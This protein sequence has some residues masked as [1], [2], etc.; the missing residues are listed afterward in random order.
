MNWIGNALLLTSVCALG[1]L[2]PAVAATY[3]E[4][5]SSGLGNWTAGPSHLDSYGIVGGELFLDG[6]GHLTGTGG[7]GVLQFNQALGSRFTATWEARITGYKY[8][9][10]TLSAEPWHFDTSLGYAKL[11]YLAWLDVDDVGGMPHFD[12]WKRTASGV[13]ALAS[14]VAM[15]VDVPSGQTMNWRLEKNGASIKVWI[16][17]YLMAD[18]SDTTFENANMKLGLSFGEDS[19]GYFDNLTVTAVPEPET[20][21]LLLAGLGA[22]G[23]AGRR[24]ASKP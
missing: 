1:A 20:Y 19:K 18:V 4:D 9:N 2:P 3:S 14:E 21:A 13:T 24:R 12:L 15:V 17:G 7:W 23:A 22:L 6:W 10:F 8:A 16:D 5:F 11:G